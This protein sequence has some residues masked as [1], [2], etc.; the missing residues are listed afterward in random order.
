MVNMAEQSSQ[1]NDQTTHTGQ[2]RNQTSIPSKHKGFYSSPQY[3]DIVGPTLP[4]I[5][6]APEVLPYE[7]RGQEKTNDP[8][9]NAKVKKACRCTST[10]LYIFMPW[11]F[12]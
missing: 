3:A 10:P 11:A 2:P 9:V 1:H 6:W 12:I 7:F 5:Q 4:P 8:H